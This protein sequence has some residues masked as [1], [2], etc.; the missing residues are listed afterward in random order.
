E[1]GGRGPQSIGRALLGPERP[2]RRRGP[3]EQ[4]AGVVEPGGLELELL[5]LARPRRRDLDLAYLVGEQIHLALAVAF[6]LVELG[7]GGPLVAE[8][9]VLDAEG[10]DGLEMLGS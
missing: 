8:A 5:G 2:L 7:Q 6:A 4:P 10:P 1:L 3:L 9:P